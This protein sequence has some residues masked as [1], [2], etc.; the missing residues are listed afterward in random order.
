MTGLMNK[1][2]KFRRNVVSQQLKPVAEPEVLHAQPL[3][4]VGLFALL[5][6]DQKSK[7]LDVSED[8]RFGSDE[9]RRCRV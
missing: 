6:E 5:D 8:E 9:F 4:M 3:P 7:A 1:V 2:L